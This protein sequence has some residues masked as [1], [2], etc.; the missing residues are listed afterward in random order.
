MCCP[1][2]PKKEQCLGRLIAFSGSVAIALRKNS[3][4]VQGRRNLSLVGINVMWLSDVLHPFEALGLALF[5]GKDVSSKIDQLI[6][7]YENY[8]D[9][10][11]DHPT[12]A[13]Q[14]FQNFQ[15]DI[16]EGLKI[17]KEMKRHYSK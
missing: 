7:Q 10:S 8:L 1:T 6:M 4:Y 11:L 17:L 5:R 16:S 14:I 3:A 12:L 9:P 15:V 13:K 2:N